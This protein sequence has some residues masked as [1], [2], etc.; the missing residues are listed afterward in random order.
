V[1]ENVPERVRWSE[2]GLETLT[3]GR[4]QCNDHRRRL[5]TGPRTFHQLKLSKVRQTGVV[6]RRWNVERLPT[7][8]VKRRLQI[9]AENHS[10]KAENTDRYFQLLMC[11]ATKITFSNIYI[12]QDRQA[13]LKAKYCPR[14]AAVSCTKKKMP[15]NPCNLDL[16]P[17]TL[18]FNRVL[19]VVEVNVHAKFHQAKCN[20]SSVINGEQL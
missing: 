2:L 17:M 5:R 7:T 8:S 4:L 18:K 14:V 9:Y 12:K 1:F 13:L 3:V 19:E 10:F 16:W 20:S 15:K 11:I 6:D